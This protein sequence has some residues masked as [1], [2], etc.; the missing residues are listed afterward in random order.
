[1]K[2]KD[3]AITVETIFWILEVEIYNQCDIFYKIE[4]L[5]KTFFTNLNHIF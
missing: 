3:S 2:N 1:M 4:S 5:L